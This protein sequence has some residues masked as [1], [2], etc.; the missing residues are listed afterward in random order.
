MALTSVPRIPPYCT[1]LLCPYCVPRMEKWGGSSRHRAGLYYCTVRDL[2][3]KLGDPCPEHVPETFE[4][5]S[6]LG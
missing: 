3:T 5:G 1:V 6:R 4:W 2:N